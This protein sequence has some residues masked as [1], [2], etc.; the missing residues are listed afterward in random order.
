MNQISKVDSSGTTSYTYDDME[1]LG[2]VTE[3][4]CKVTEYA[5]DVAGN[6]G[7]K[8][9]SYQGDD[10]VTMYTYNTQNR[11]VD[12]LTELNDVTAETVDYT[13]DTTATSSQPRRPQFIGGVPQ[14][15]ST[16]ANTYDALN[17][18]GTT[19]HSGSF[20][21]NTYN[22][23]GLRVRK[24]V[25]AET[26]KIPVRRR[27][28]CA[29]AGRL[30]QPDSQRGLRDEPDL[31]ECER[32]HR[33]LLVQRTWRRHIADRR[34]RNHTGGLLLRR[35]WQHRVEHWGDRQSVQVRGGYRYDDETGYYYLMSRYYDPV[36][37]RF[38]KRGQLQGPAIRPA[39]PEPVRVCEQQ[40]DH[41]HR[42][43]GALYLAHGSG[44][45]DSFS[46]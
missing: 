42:S 43:D 15:P 9:V 11:L 33:L 2:T 32:R 31:Q 17:Q 34:Q 26:V 46:D 41:L 13:Y 22:G 24:Q 16:V 38:L 4:S 8:T 14:T 12:T 30:K 40:P 7:S 27:Q 10:T 18:L 1:R 3:P 39:E 36:T 5:F 20:T 35:V 28:G 37:A 23:E 19:A 6:R 29:R 25:D 45:S 21:T 44:E